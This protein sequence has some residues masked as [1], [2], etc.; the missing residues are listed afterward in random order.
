MPSLRARPKAVELGDP[1]RVVDRAGGNFHQCLRQ[2]H[3]LAPPEPISHLPNSRRR[4]IERRE[5]C[6]SA[7]A[8]VVPR[9]FDEPTKSSR[10][11]FAREKEETPPDACV[12][13]H[14]A[15][16]LFC[17]RSKAPDCMVYRPADKIRAG[18]RSFATAA[19]SFPLV[20]ILMGSVSVVPACPAALSPATQS[21]PH[22]SFSDLS[23]TTLGATIL[24]G[25]R[26]RPNPS[27]TRFSKQI[28]A[29]FP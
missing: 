2:R 28:Y 9:R 8:R 20:T 15:N 13:R 3:S 26:T 11:R 1:D 16:L 22:L 19:S 29:L 6:D 10:Q 5:T 14:T 24:R 23:T 4:A 25:A 18:E 17:R 27:C 21:F 7:A 12:R